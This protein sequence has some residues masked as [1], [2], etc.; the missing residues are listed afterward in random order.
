M[1]G[2]NSAED[3]GIFV[4]CLSGVE[5]VGAIK[6]GNDVGKV[7]FEDFLGDVGSGFNAAWRC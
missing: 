4:A 7:R 5:G 2:Q 3:F 6:L 1:V